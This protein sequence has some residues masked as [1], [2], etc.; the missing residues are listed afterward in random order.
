MDKPDTPLYG[1]YQ[2]DLSEGC[3]SGYCLGEFVA[4]T[5]HSGHDGVSGVRDV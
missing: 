4:A 2:A 5:G 3:E 1:H